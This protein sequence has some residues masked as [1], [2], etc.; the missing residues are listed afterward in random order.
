MAPFNEKENARPKKTFNR[1]HRHRHPL[2]QVLLRRHRR[3]R[4]RRGTFPLYRKY[5]SYFTAV[6][7]TGASFDPSQ[8]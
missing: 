4:R 3:R 7:D 8:K 1:R 2:G 5:R 6:V